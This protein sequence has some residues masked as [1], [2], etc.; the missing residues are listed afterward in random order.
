MR[1]WI[2][3]LLTM[4][5]AHA[6]PEPTPQ[7]WQPAQLSHSYSFDLASKIT[8]QTYRILIAEPAGPAP[9]GGY[10]VL[11]MLDGLASF[12]AMEGVRIKPK[13][14]GESAAWRQEKGSKPAGLI[15]AVGYASGQAFDV[16]A[17]ALDYTPKVEGVSG[18][19]FS[20]RHGRADLF[21]RFLIEEL[22]PE[23]ARHFPVN[24]RA[25]TLFGFS[26]GGL[27]T[28][29]V[30]STA[31]QHF[32][33]YWAASPSLWFDEARTLNRLPARLKT[34]H[35]D[36]ATRVQITV[37]QDE[38]YP[39]RF[40]SE[41]VKAKLQ[42]RA[43]VDHAQSFAR[44]LGGALKVEFTILPAHDHLDTFYHGTRRVAD[45]AFATETKP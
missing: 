36:P 24:P 41:T 30:L 19:L 23:I 18:D 9:A 4:T 37:G 35:L 28:L 25:N 42:Q 34:V 45:F 7:S 13:S 32:Q 31:A 11:W 10:P 29:Y 1:F 44:Q 38:Q 21:L 6:A 26:Y 8:G 17:R 43:M 27:F 12:P 15:V 14:V 16:D 39:P 20:P 3:L 22:R 40:A 2:L 33:R 5:L